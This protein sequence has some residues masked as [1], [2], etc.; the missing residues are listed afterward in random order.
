MANARI[1]VRHTPHTHR[2]HSFCPSPSFPARDHWFVVP[3]SKQPHNAPLPGRSL[4]APSRR[5][6]TRRHGRPEPYGQGSPRAPYGQGAPRAH[7]MA[8][9]PANEVTGTP[10]SVLEH[11]FDQQLSLRGASADATPF[12]LQAAEAAGHYAAAPLDPWSTRLAPPS[13]S[14][15]RPH[16]TPDGTY[17]PRE[18]PYL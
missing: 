17:V 2:S 15:P 8:H 18:G 6:N 7:K 5:D 1:Y 9:A 14:G 4:E 12:F 3:L 11:S 16:R 10:C 13:S